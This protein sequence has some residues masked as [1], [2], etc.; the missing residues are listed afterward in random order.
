MEMERLKL[1]QKTPR[2]TR[3]WKILALV[4]VVLLLVAALLLYYALSTP[5]EEH[6]KAEYEVAAAA[7]WSDAWF[8]RRYYSW[9]CF[10]NWKAWQIQD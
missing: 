4:A 2:Q 6:G 10:G 1:A 7:P 8:L 5:S 9:R 3:R